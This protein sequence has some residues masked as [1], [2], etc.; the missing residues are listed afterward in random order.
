MRLLVKLLL[1]NMFSFE[2][3]VV[4]IIKISHD[5]LTDHEKIYS[6]VV[7]DIYLLYM[8]VF[9]CA[10]SGYL[11]SNLTLLRTQPVLTFK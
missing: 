11:F 7:K 3:F 9:G 10:T 1:R 6:D 2:T 4:I 5:S 8:Y